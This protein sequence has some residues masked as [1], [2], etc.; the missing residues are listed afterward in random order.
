MKKILP[1]LLL[2]FAV[3]LNIQAQQLA[4]PGA[5]GFGKFARGARASSNPTVYR[6]TNLNDAGSGS[7]RDAVSASNRIVVFDV[8]GVIRISSRMWFLQ[9]FILQGKLHRAKV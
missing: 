9:I 4:F 3:L 7:F 5:E 2:V 6:V 8:A 1:V